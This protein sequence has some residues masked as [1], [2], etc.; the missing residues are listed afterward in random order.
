MAKYYNK[1][2]TPLS[3]TL[4]DGSTAY[5][6]PKRWTK[7]TP[8]QEGA[9]AV[10]QLVKKGFLARR[11][12]AVPAPVEVP[13]PEPAPA[14]PEPAPVPEPV[15]PKAPEPPEPVAEVVVEVQPVHV[16]VPPE[17]IETS[18]DAD[19]TS[20]SDEVSEESVASE[21]STDTE[22]KTTRRSKSRRR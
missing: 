6:A 9:A 10:I 21:E 20:L 16:D 22:S 1:T 14:A 5:F 8:A 18:L 15:L 4:R 2:R 12:D 17:L 3:A 11:A 7:L 19:H 13:K